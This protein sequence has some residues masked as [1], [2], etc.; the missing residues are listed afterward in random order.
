MVA[1]T[2]KMYVKHL[3]QSPTL[4]EYP[5]YFTSPPP[6]EACLQYFFGIQCL[7][8]GTVIAALVGFY[9]QPLTRSASQASLLP[10]HFSGCIFHRELV[11]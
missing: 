3:T 1:F 2:V 8:L 9:G 6:P 4:S 10:Q 7:N 5:V 11:T